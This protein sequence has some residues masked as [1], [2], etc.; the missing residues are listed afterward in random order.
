MADYRP[1]FHSLMCHAD[2]QRP[3]I[4]PEPKPV[5]T[6][7]K[8]FLIKLC[9]IILPCYLYANGGITNPFK[10]QNWLSYI[11]LIACIVFIFF[12]NSESDSKYSEHFAFL[13][14]IV[15]FLSMGWPWLYVLYVL[16]TN[17]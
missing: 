8:S 15:M 17:H 11:P 6:Q 13:A 4:Q 14:L 5:D 2:A 12:Q 16:I 9:T 10:S 3:E 1:S 7:W